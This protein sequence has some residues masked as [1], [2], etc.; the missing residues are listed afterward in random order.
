MTHHDSGY[1][2]TTFRKICFDSCLDDKKILYS[3]LFFFFFF[4][5]HVEAF[6]AKGDTGTSVCKTKGDSRKV[7]G[8]EWEEVSRVNAYIEGKG[9]LLLD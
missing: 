5:P 6:K 4:E 1:G 2:S 8:S 7:S 3:R 9:K